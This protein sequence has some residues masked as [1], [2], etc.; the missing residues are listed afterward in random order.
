MKTEQREAARELR[1]QGRSVNEIVRELGVAKSSVS[2]WVRDVELTAEQQHELYNRRG[3][4]YRAQANGSKAVATKYREMRRE[5][6]EEGRAKAREMDPLHIA[7]CMLYWAEGRKTRNSLTFVNSDANMLVFYLRFLR[8][9]LGITNNQIIIRL[10]YYIGNGLSSEEI[11]NYW[12]TLLKLP[13]NCL[14]KVHAVNNQPISSN[15]RGR[16][17][18]HGTCEVAVHNTQIVQQIMG[19]IQEYSGID[20]PEWLD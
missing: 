5:Y 4:R 6:Q 10:N 15:Q 16:K 2:M 12:L 1:R 7:G 11:E 3:P 13:R 17:L 14:A 8:H 18:L 20:N 9:S 19:A